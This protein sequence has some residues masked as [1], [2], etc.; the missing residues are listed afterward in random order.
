MDE[1]SAENDVL[2]W[3]N[4]SPG[5]K[6]VAVVT[7]EEGWAGASLSISSVTITGKAPLTTES[8]SHTLSGIMADSHFTF[9]APPSGIIF[10]EGTDV[11]NPISFELVRCPLG[12]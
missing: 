4:L 8:G 10:L 2:T 5:F 3:P 1:I 6:Y 9:I 11:V 12:A 7:C